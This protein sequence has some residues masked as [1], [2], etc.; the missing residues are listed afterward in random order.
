MSFEYFEKKHT[1]I[2]EKLIKEQGQ[3]DEYN[4]IMALPKFQEYILKLRV[5][6]EVGNGSEGENVNRQKIVCQSLHEID[7][8]SECK[9]MLDAINKYD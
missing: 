3:D 7:Y 9:Q 8:A 5:K 4:R 1:N 6:F 2:E